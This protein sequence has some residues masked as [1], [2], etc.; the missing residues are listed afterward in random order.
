MIS[1]LGRKIKQNRCTKLSF[2]ILV[3]WNVDLF[4]GIFFLSASNAVFLWIHVKNDWKNNGDVQ[5]IITIEYDYLIVF[6]MQPC[7]CIFFGPEFTWNQPVT[8][9]IPL[10]YKFQRLTMSSRAQSALSTSWASGP[11]AFSCCLIPAVCSFYSSPFF[12]SSRSHF[13][14]LPHRYPIQSSEFPWQLSK[15]G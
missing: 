3:D 13:K 2:I 8:C 1:N 15:I 10:M 4:L 11:L 7:S 14:N 9:W 5:S 6:H 12:T